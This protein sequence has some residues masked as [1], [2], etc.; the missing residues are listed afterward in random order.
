VEAHQDGNVQAVA[1]MPRN[2]AMERLDTW[3][4][5]DKINHNIARLVWVVATFDDLDIASLWVARRGGLSSP[6][7]CSL[8]YDP[9]VVL[10]VFVRMY[11]IAV[12]T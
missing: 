7:P 3:V 5:G 10:L 4:V 11:M 1:S 6:F 8:C 9:E 2:V 12:V